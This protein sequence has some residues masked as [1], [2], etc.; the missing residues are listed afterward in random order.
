MWTYVPI[1]VKRSKDVIYMYILIYFASAVC[2]N[3][4][5]PLDKNLHSMH[6][7]FFT[8]SHYLCTN[9]RSKQPFLHYNS[10]TSLS[11]CNFIYTVYGF[12]LF[13]KYINIYSV[14]F[15]VLLQN[16]ID[17]AVTVEYRHFIIIINALIR[18]WNH[19]LF[20]FC[21]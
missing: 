7:M 8:L 5:N 6:L 19:V 2:N 13:K 10:R 20:C 1:I 18:L 9:A 21:Y 12:V 4:T 17:Q 15:Y 14:Y 11:L 3:Q 16:Q